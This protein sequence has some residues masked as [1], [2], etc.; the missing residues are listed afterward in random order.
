MLNLNMEV[1]PGISLDHAMQEAKRLA[2]RLSCIVT[3]QFNDAEYSV[4]G[5]D[6]VAEEMAEFSWGNYEQ[7]HVKNITDPERLRYRALYRRRK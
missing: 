5:H 2:D 7:E 1:L 3:F 6:A 4:T